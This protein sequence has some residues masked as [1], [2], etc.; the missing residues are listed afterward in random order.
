MSCKPCNRHFVDASALAQHM[1]DS[2]S[3]GGFYCKQCKR[4]FAS[5]N[6]LQS[7]LHNS[8][9]HN[10]CYD[11]GPNYKFETMADYRQHLSE[12][13][14]YCDQC[15]VEFLDLDTLH[16]HDSRKHH[17][18]S[19]CDRVFY[20]PNSFEMVLHTRHLLFIRRGA[21]LTIVGSTSEFMT[22]RL[23]DHHHVP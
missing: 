21:Y 17:I 8:S 5:L 18:C 7:H 1:R 14:W 23:S 11:C 10:T 4:K 22:R 16:E 9:A 12:C 13:H 6:A 19:I 3:H 20:A 15:D 2:S